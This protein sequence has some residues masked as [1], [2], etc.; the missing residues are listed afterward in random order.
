MAISEQLQQQMKDDLEL[1]VSLSSIQD[2]NA[3]TDLLARFIGYLET[4]TS[5]V[6]ELEY[7]ASQLKSKSKAVQEYIRAIKQHLQNVSIDQSLT[8]KGV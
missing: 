4:T 3:L 6:A 2:L 8:R 7:K 5:A 1:A